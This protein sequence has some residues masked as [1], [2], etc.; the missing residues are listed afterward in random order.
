MEKRYIIKSVCTATPENDNFAG[1][2]RTYY[3]G[4]GNKLIGSDDPYFG[5]PLYGVKLYGYTRLGD[6]KRNYTFRNSQ[7]DKWWKRE[8]SIEEIEC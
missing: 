7:N 8:V 5:Y 3:N 1:V 6:A 4:I 2:V